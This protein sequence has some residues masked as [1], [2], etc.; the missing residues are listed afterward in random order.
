MNHPETLTRSQAV[1]NILATY[2]LMY[3]KLANAETDA[4]EISAEAF[5]SLI[6][7]GVHPAEIASALADL[8]AEVEERAA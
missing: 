2:A 4:E 6:V 8:R 1:G 7:L 5:D 3:V